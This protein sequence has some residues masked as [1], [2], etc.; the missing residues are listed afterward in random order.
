MTI[1]EHIRKARKDRGLTQKQLSEISDISVMSISSYETGR[2]FP[3]LIILI[4]LAD[5]LNCTI[6][7]LIGRER[8]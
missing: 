3:S 6:D 7:E 1:G 2:F 4:A 5:A 8:K